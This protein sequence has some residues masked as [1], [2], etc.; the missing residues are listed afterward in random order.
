MTRKQKADIFAVIIVVG[1]AL[2]VFYHYVLSNY[3]GL[4]YYPY[5]TFLFS[6]GDKFN[7]FFNIYR[8]T[9]GLDPYVFPVSVY[10]PFTFS[11]MYL[12]TI[13][14]TKYIFALLTIAFIGFFATYIYKNISFLDRTN[15]YLF[16]FSFTFMT[17]PILFALDRGNVEIFLFVFLA[18]FMYAYQKGEDWKSMIFLSFAIAMK[19]YPIVFITLFL[20]DKKYKQAIITILLVI[21]ISLLSASILNGGI[22]NSFAGI[23]SNL[24]LFNK[25]YVGTDQGLQHNS[26]LY[27]LFEI[28][29]RFFLPGLSF[30]VSYYLYIVSIFL[31]AIFLYVLFIEKTLWKKVALLTLSIIL[32]PQVSFDYKLIHLFIPIMLFVNAKSSR[33]GAAY[34]AM[35]A[36]LLIPKDYYL[37]TADISIAVVIN[38]LLMAAI[39]GLIFFERFR[40]KEQVAA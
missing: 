37:I 20:A 36:L 34:A 29:Q 9:I 19:L 21:G 25:G 10:F 35:L 6:P 17:Y 28:S 2:S 27:G 32:F 39:I 5:N 7:D 30:L 18:L 31:G 8:A 15:K 22:I 11:I 33:F 12:F 13:L 38:P 3:F 14:N 23:S 1:F 4:N 40:Y 16:V 26:S 24:A